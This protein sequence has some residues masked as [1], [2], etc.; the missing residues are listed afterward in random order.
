MN[1]IAQFLYPY[2]RNNPYLINLIW[3]KNKPK[4]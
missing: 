4:N 3:I 1:E 2:Y